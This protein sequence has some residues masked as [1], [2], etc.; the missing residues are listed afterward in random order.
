M[1][2]NKFIAILVLLVAA[3]A[4]KLTDTDLEPIGANNELAEHRAEPVTVLAQVTDAN[5]TMSDVLAGVK[6]V[7]D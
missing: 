5:I 2:M 7:F 6:A 4:L 3:S 1:I